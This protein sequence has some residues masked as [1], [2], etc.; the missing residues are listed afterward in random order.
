MTEHEEPPTRVRIDQRGSHFHGLT[1]VITE[2]RR[3]A[4]TNVFVTFDEPY[5]SAAGGT[6][7]GAWFGD[8]E[9]EVLS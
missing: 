5:V 1:G 8:V 6:I 4:F 9:L 7:E 3:T 2:G